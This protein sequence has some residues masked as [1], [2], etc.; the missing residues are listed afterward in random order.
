[1]RDARIP[2]RRVGD[3][4]ATLAAEAGITVFRVGFERWVDPGEQRPMPVLMRE[5]LQELRAVTA[6]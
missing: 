2:A 1:M 3:S 5:A 4:R 6:A